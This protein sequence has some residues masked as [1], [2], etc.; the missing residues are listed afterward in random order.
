MG[1]A[2]FVPYGENSDACCLR[3]I[4]GI[5]SSKSPNKRN[6]KLHVAKTS[7]DTVKSYPKHRCVLCPNQNH[8]LY[9]CHRFKK[10]SFDQKITVVKKYG[11]CFNCLSRGHS[12]SNCPSAHSCYVCHEKHHTL[13]HKPKRSTPTNSSSSNV[14]PT[15]RVPRTASNSILDNVASTS[16]GAN[17]TVVNRQ[18]FHTSHNS[19]VLLSTAMVNIIHEG[20]SYPVRALIDPASEASFITEHLQTRSKLSSRSTLATISGVNVSSSATIR[21]NCRICISSRLSTSTFHRFLLT[22]L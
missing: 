19:R 8:A 11:L 20:N 7:P 21:K 17:P 5:D 4:K 10:M 16:T 3:D 15:V 14:T 1:S 13:M 22:L 2:Q 18:V 12:V 9:S 6:V